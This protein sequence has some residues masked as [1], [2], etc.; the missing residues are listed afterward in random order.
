MARYN[1]FTFTSTKLDTNAFNLRQLDGWSFTPGASV[2]EIT[3]GG[4]VDRAHIG[5]S[6]ANPSFGLQTRDLLTV[7]GAMTPATV[8]CVTAAIF[9][10]QL[11]AECSTFATGTNHLSHSVPKGTIIPRSINASQTDVDG[12]SMQLEML[13]L[14][15]GTDAIVSAAGS[16]D[17]DAVTTPAF[18]SRYYMGPI[19]INGTIVPNLESWGV[20]FGINYQTKAFNGSPYPTEGSIITRK[21]VISLTGSDLAIQAAQNLFLRSAAGAIAIYAQAGTAGSDRVAAGT[22]GHVKITASAGAISGQNTSITGNDDGT[23]TLQIMPTAAL[24]VATN[25]TIP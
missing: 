6:S 7:F 10:A 24:A 13:P 5:L 11:R 25:S 15:N 12:V 3:P 16:Q 19:Y 1:M 20:D 2:G 21:P 22:G 23:V 4:A 17:Y 8:L 14:F 9:R 18:V